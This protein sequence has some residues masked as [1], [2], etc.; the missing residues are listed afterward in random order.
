[1]MKMHQTNK[2]TNKIDSHH[3][4]FSLFFLS[5][6]IGHN[7]RYGRRANNMPKS[8]SFHPSEFEYRC[9]TTH[10]KNDIRLENCSIKK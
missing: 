3:H 8:Y 6:N 7:M 9:D 10:G 4:L 2:Q 5:H 1:M